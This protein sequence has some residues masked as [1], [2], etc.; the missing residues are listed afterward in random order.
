MSWKK[1]KLAN[2][3]AHIGGQKSDLLAGEEVALM[4]SL[5]R[6][7]IKGKIIGMRIYPRRIQKNF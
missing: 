6:K 3:M 2:D 4:K 5:T 7:E 1:S